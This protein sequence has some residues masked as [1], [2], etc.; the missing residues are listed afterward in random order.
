MAS[1]IVRIVND[2]TIPSSAGF[3]DHYCVSLTTVQD[4]KV[5][6]QLVQPTAM[7]HVV[8]PSYIGKAVM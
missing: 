4:I 3:C 6:D 5:A 8:N 2:T 1:E 7:L